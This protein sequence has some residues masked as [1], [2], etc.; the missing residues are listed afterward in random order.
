MVA[1]ELGHS[2]VIC[3]FVSVSV[4]HVPVQQI[5]GDVGGGAVQPLCINRSL[6]Y[7]EVVPEEVVNVDRRFPVKL[8]GDLAPKLL[9]IVDAL[10]VQFLVLIEGWNV[11][12]FCDRRM[13]LINGL[14]GWHV[15]VAIAL[16]RNDWRIAVVNVVPDAKRL[17][18]DDGAFILKPGLRAAAASDNVL[19]ATVQWRWMR[20]Y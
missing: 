20:R 8:A 3:D 1:G 16:A 12:V 15:V 19:I 14:F 4:P 9:R 6:S 2:P 7:V 10:L 11:R 13:R 18:A 17:T 5:V